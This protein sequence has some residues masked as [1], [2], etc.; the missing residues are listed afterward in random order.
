MS[1]IAALSS[2]PIFIIIFLFF[3]FITTSPS[4]PTIFSFNDT[5][6]ELLELELL[7][8]FSLAPDSSSLLLF[9]FFTPPLSRPRASLLFFR[10]LIPQALHK[11][12][13]QGQLKISNYDRI[14][15]LSNKNHLCLILAT[16]N[17]RIKPKLVGSSHS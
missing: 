3:L 6:S 12:C 7:L 10:Y 5:P 4:R 11:D 8:F 13:T 14:F 17:E 2:S 15:K 16:S 9:S 1:S